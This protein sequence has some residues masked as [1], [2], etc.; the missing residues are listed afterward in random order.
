MGALLSFLRK[1]VSLLLK[2]IEILSVIIAI[3]EAA[4]KIQSA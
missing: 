2:M 3:L 4:D 1:V